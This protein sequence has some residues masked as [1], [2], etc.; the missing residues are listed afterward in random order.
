MVG[1]VAFYTQTLGVLARRNLGDSTAS[2]GKQLFYTGVLK[3]VPEVSNQVSIRTPTGWCTTWGL[4]WRTIA[5]T[6]WA[7][8]RR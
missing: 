4:P 2:R 8:R 5:P 6:S 1:N 3:S 7:S